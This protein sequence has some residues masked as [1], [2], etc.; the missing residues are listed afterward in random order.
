VSSAKSG[1]T[2]RSDA[3]LR[4][5]QDAVHSGEMEGLTVSAAF[6]ADAADYASGAIDIAEFG[7]RVRARNGVA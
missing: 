4:A 1:D 3:R 6:E 5:V 2:A 7:Q